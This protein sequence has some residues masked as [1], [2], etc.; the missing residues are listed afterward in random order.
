MLLCSNNYFK[1]VAQSNSFKKRKWKRLLGHQA[2]WTGCHRRAQHRLQVP[3]LLQGKLRL[4]LHRSDQWTCTAKRLLPSV[5][6]PKPKIEKIIKTV[7]LFMVLNK[8]HISISFGRWRAEREN[9]RCWGSIIITTAT[10][11]T[12]M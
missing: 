7:P 4:R 11:I 12:E 2:R 9:C 3:N 6:C 8:V 1:I 10:T 5:C